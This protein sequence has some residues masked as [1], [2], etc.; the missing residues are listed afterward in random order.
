MRINDREE[1]IE[2]IKLV[3]VLEGKGH[4]EETQS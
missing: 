4:L 2:D 1:L 3:V